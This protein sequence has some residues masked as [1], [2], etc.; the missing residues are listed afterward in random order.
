MSCLNIKQWDPNVTSFPPC[1]ASWWTKAVRG[2]HISSATGTVGVFDS[3]CQMVKPC[4]DAYFWPEPGVWVGVT[5]CS[6]SLKRSNAKSFSTPRP[7]PCR[8][9]RPRPPVL[10]RPLANNDRKPPR[11]AEE[12]AKRWKRKAR[13][14]V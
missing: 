11:G 13:M 1:R 5:T 2:S 3:P 4:R 10:P 6:S 12:R 14:Q 8:R 9:A 7:R